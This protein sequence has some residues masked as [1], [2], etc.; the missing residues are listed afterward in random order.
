LQGPWPSAQ[1]TR[2]NSVNN[3]QHLHRTVPLLLVVA[4]VRGHLKL[5]IILYHSL[6]FS[7]CYLSSLMFS[8]SHVI[9]PPAQ[10]LKPNNLPWC[11]AVSVGLWLP[12]PRLCPS[13]LAGNFGF[14][15]F[16]LQ[17]QCPVSAPS[18]LSS[19]QRTRALRCCRGTASKQE[20]NR[21]E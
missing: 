4:I 21:N 8:L 6:S 9:S 18:C 14:S 13:V 12:S 19:G 20:K 10:G 5:S 17:H 15:A 7:I 3:T 16:A 1:I 2:F 11:E